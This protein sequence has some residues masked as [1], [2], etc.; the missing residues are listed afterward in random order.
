M[1]KRWA[2]LSGKVAA[3]RPVA[4]YMNPEDLRTAL[5]GARIMGLPS[6][7]P[8]EICTECQVYAAAQDWAPL[9]A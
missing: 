9:P 5:C 2:P 7:E 6:F 3:L 8:F 1:H 4:H